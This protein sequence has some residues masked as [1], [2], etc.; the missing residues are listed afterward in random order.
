MDIAGM[1]GDISNA[2]QGVFGGLSG[3]I[4]TWNEPKIAQANAFQSAV[5]A[6]QSN[7]NMTTYLMFAVIGLV[8]WKMFK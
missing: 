2:V 6:M 7:Q 3:V 8:A 4:K 1:I 5:G